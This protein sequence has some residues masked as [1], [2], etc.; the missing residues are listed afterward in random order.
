MNLL[1]LIFGDWLLKIRSRIIVMAL[2]RK[3]IFVG[4]NVFFRATPILRMRGVASNL[5]IGDRCTFMGPVEFNNRELGRIELGSDCVIDGHCRLLAANQA[6]LRLG[7]FNTLGMGSIINAGV[8][9]TIGDHTLM[10]G[11]CYLQTSNHQT[12]AG[13][14][15]RKQGYEHGTITLGSDVW[16]A[17]NVTLLG[18]ITIHD[19]AVIGAKS[20]VTNDIPTNAIAVGTPAKTIKQREKETT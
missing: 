2:R 9:V 19:G 17:G 14:L 11:Y 6:T 18:G 5:S 13:E 12:K 8:D 20:V 3:G 16:L 1:A 15:I 4:E 7:H 10:G